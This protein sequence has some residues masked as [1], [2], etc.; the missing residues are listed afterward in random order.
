MYS[1][2]KAFTAINWHAPWLAPY[3]PYGMALTKAIVL[4]CPA[5]AALNEALDKNP[6]LNFPVRFVKQEESSGA[7]AY[8]T[9]IFDTKTV[10]TRDNLHDFFNGLVWLR[11]PKIKARL[12]EL[13]AAAIQASGGVGQH[14][15]RLR[16]AL[17]LFDENA[18]FI[19]ESNTE[20]PLL[21]AIRHKAWRDAFVMQR[22]AWQHTQII[23]FGHALLEKLVTPR[24]PMTAHVFCPPLCL[25]AIDDESIATQLN[26]EHLATKPFAPLPVLGIPFWCAENEDAMFYDDAT[27]FRLP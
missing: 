20:S 25:N 17:T 24:K 27:V 1:T 5:H 8:E 26:A 2:D 21:Q 12:N 9:F 10:P 15:G 6:R 11:F 16:D 23:I 7:A 14:R 19:I 22:G 3:K 4:G 13:Q 18:A